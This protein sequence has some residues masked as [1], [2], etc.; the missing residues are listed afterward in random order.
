MPPKVAAAPKPA[1]KPKGKKAAPPP[2][3]KVAA[4]AA[5]PPAAKAPQNVNLGIK[6]KRQWS[7]G[8]DVPYKRDL[9]RFLRWPDYVWRQRRMRILHHRLRRPPA[10]NQFALAAD[11][12]LRKELFKLLAKYKPEGKAE[13]KARLKKAAAAKAEADKKG[14]KK[15]AKKAAPVKEV[16]AP[17]LRYG[18]KCVTRLIEQG[19]A[20]LVLI[21]HDVDP[22]ELVL[23]LPALCHKLNVPYAIVKGKARLGALCGFK[24]ATCVALDKI[25][26][27][28]RATLV[29]IIESV[30]T[31]FAGKFDEHRKAW[32]GLALGRR[33]NDRMKKRAR[34]LAAAP[35]ASK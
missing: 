16:R 14:D 19:K 17:K 32:G 35:G 31:N 8:C 10:V 27:D 22:I 1:A 33:H 28:D 5:A 2:K 4:K 13:R 9:T 15:G 12:Q 21:A 20:K 6:R 23:C 11:A 18:L 29:K 24:T 3:G 7:I 26:E 34:L 30:N 25:K